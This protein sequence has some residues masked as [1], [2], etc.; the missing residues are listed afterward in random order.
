MNDPDNDLVRQAQNGDRQAFGVLVQRHQARVFQFVRR[1]QGD[2]D[3]ALDITQDSFIKAW[4]ALDRWRPEARFLTWLLQIARNTTFDT[5]RQRQRQPLDSLESDD[6]LIDPGA[7]PLRLLEGA[8]QLTRLEQHLARLSMEH[9]E[10]LLLR[11]V[12]G[13]SYNE[14]ASTLG[15][16]EGTVKSR[17][18][19][20]R[21]T[22]LARYRHT[23]EGLCHD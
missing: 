10:I 14:L 1:L 13:L 19:R 8:R 18:A 2:A 5:L 22:L 15:I 7:S 11:E 20:A 17:L 9:R 21:E 16:S 12:E 4:G 6:L 23:P 3:E